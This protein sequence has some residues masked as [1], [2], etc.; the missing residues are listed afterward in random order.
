MQRPPW[1]VTRYKQADRPA[2]Q[3]CRK[4]LSLSMLISEWVYKLV[5]LVERLF[6]LVI[7]YLLRPAMLQ[8][9]CLFW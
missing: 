1:Y 2:E 9:R 6:R 5:V 7:R 8:F 3:A 4:P